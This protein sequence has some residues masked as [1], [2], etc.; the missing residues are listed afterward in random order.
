MQ[1]NFAETMRQ[2]SA[3]CRTMSDQ[4]KDRYRDVSAKQSSQGATGARRRSHS[5]G[6]GSSQRR[7]TSVSDIQIQIQIY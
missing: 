5:S 7:S 6:G 4:E 3:A 2:W 1:E